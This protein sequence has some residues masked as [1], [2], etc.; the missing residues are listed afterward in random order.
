MYRCI[1]NCPTAGIMPINTTYWQLVA[2]KGT[3]GGKGDKGNDGAPGEMAPIGK[4]LFRNPDFSQGFNGIYVYNNYGNGNT[5]IDRI[6]R[7][8][9]CPNN[10]THC[11]RITNNGYATPGLGG[12]YFATNMSRPNAKFMARIIAKIPVGY[13]I[14]WAS[15]PIG[16]EGYHKWITSQDGTDKFEEY[17]CIVQCGITGAFSSTNFFYL[18]GEYGTAEKPVVWYLAYATVFD[19]TQAEVDYL[20]EIDNSIDVQP[21]YVYRGNYYSYVGY[22]G[23]NQRVDIVKYNNV[24]YRAKRKLNGSF[25]N[26]TPSDNSDYWENFGAQFESIATNL[27]LAE[28]ANIGDWVIKSGKITSQRTTNDGTSR[29]QLN[30]ADGKISF[31]SDI[32]KYTAS[33]GTT[34]VKQTILLDSQLGDIE[35]RT[36]DGDVSSMNSQGIFTNRAG[37]QALPSS[38][39]VEL[40]AAIV[41]VGYGN[42]EKTAYS[43]VG[44]LCG[45]YATA[46]NNSYNPAPTWGAYIN[47]LLANGMYFAY[48]R[49]SGTTWLNENDTYISCYNTG[50]INVYLP[51]SPQNGMMLFVRR[52]NNASVVVYGNGKSIHVDG[53]TPSSLSICGG[54]GDTAIFIYDGQY[55]NY[56]YMIR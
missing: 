16:E 1:Q 10:S 4:M 23:S 54:R 19:A 25:S 26:Q 43:S 29:A 37:I 39:G 18:N 49:I 3:D 36:S 53:S 51:S 8:N 44:A 21:T 15:N 41:A 17:I 52:M 45:L 5:F 11:L 35:V 56:N 22:T 2:Q 33:G 48:R 24:Y 7:I 30:G 34:I 13:Y 46:S 38:V 20:K 6:E 31:A 55:W 40:K 50:T 12:F 9:D 32:S 14:E 42:L 47:K 27:I 28:G